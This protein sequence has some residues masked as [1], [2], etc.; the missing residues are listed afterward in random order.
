MLS[1]NCARCSKIL[2]RLAA[3]LKQLRKERSISQEDF[4]HKAGLHR[5]GYGWIEQRKRTPK[6]CDFSEDSGSIRRQ[7]IG[8]AFRR[9]SS[10][11]ETLGARPCIFRGVET[12]V[13]RNGIALR[14]LAPFNRAIREFNPQA[15]A[16]PRS[17]QTINHSSD[18]PKFSR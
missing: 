6:S 13:V 9:G 1:P 7:F 10:K 11:E 16:I 14:M 8:P 3:R 18:L 12:R 15:K 4:A 5:V 2:A 17:W